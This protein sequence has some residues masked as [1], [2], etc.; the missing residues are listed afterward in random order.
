[1]AVILQEEIREIGAG[2]MIQNYLCLLFFEKKMTRQQ[3][4][5]YQEQ[6]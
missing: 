2:S 3:A 1:M 4:L 5:A 6:I